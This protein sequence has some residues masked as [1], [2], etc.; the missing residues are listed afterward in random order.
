MRSYSASSY[1]GYS[2]LSYAPIN[3]ETQQGKVVLIVD[4]FFAKSSFVNAVP[5][6][7]VILVSA[8]EQLK[9]FNSIGSI[10]AKLVEM[11]LRRT[12]KIIAV[13]G[14]TVQDCVGFIASILY[15]GVDWEFYPTTLASQADSCV[16]SKTSINFDNYKNLLGT[17]WSPSSIHIDVSF[18]SSLS[19]SQ[20]LCG[21]GEILH[22][23]LLD[24]RF[25]KQD[26]ERLYEL[27]D[28]GRTTDF[29]PLI[30]RTHDLKL[31]VIATDE[32]DMGIRQLFNF[33]HT[34]GHAIEAAS[35]FS[36][37]HGV[38]VLLGI[39][40]ANNFSKIVYCS[41]CISDS[42]LDLCD[43]FLED[44]DIEAINLDWQEFLRALAR[45]KKNSNSDGFTC[46][47]TKGQGKMSLENI[48][49]EM[50]GD[51]LR[52]VATEMGLIK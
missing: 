12:D 13:G 29:L 51:A 5:N 21:V 34:F 2:H 16:G 48:S 39:V 3:L 41:N 31:E 30:Q 18:L 47:L 24:T 20:L 9:D 28:C 23:W 7:R 40:F 37:R 50:Y 8:N 22:Y 33:G 14:G 6:S 36:I 38:A 19:K 43:K 11:K 46:V 10:I 25:E 49:F 44:I 17:F 42:I 32:R 4:S 35:Q 27:Y 15:R 52:S 45:D 26:F 1:S